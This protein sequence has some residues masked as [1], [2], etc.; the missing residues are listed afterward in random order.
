MLEGFDLPNQFS[1][2]TPYLG[3][4]HF[5]GADD[6][7]GVN[8]EAPADVHPGVFIVHAI[9]TANPS[10][11]IGEKRERYPTLHHFGQFF[12]LPDFVGKTAIGADGKNFHPKGFQFRIFDGNCRQFGWSDKS[13]IARIEADD[14]PLPFVI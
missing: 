1:D 10:A 14:N 5:H 4:Q 11:G 2:V 3:R 8:D 7:I 9:D 6:K 13:E 12:F